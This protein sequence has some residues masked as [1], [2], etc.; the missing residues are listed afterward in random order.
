MEIEPL[1]PHEAVPEPTNK[2]PLAAEPFPVLKTIRPLFPLPIA[3][4]ESAVSISMAPLVDVALYPDLIE[5]RPPTPVVSE[6]VPAD[7]ISSPPEPLSPDPTTTYM[8]PARPEL[9]NPEPK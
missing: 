1:A 9:A 4:K 8:L 3:L 5:R 6:V 7:R 2:P